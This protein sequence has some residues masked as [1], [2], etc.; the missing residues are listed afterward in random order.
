MSDTYGPTSRSPLAHYDP[1]SSSW[2]MSQ[3]TLPWAE[4]Q[5]LDRL[6]DWGMAHGGALFGLPTPALLTAVRDCSSLLPTPVADHSRGLPQPGTDYA[7]LPN[8][9]VS[10]LPTPSVA[11]GMGGH[12]SRSGDR[13]HELLLP[14]IV[15]TLLPTPAVN[16]MGA[17]KTVEAWDSWTTTMQAKHGNGNDHGKSL[18]IEAARISASTPPPFAAGN[19]SSDDPHPTPPNQAATDPD[20]LPGLSSGSWGYRTAG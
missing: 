18:H 16:D 1:E 20:Y 13:S 15:K 5:L 14:G 8:V 3:G 12:L 19:Q 9:A 4:A 6:P 10:L 11:D 17:G 2:R 7:S